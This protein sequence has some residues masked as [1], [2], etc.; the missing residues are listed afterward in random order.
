MTAKQL[1]EKA[2]IADNSKDWATKPDYTMPI[3]IV[4]AVIAGLTR[5]I[6]HNELN[7]FVS[8]CGVLAFLLQSSGQHGS[9]RN[10]L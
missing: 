6:S 1:R 8:V 5:F 3:I 9:G 2:G 7:N 4:V 10:E